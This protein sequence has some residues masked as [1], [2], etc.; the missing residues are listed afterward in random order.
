MELENI[1]KKWLKKLKLNEPLISTILGAV[2]IVIVGVLI[3]NYFKTSKQGEIVTE[4]AEKGSVEFVQNEQGETIPVNLPETYKV[5]ALDNLWKI[6]EKFY[7][8][9]YNWVDIAKANNITNPNQIE[10]GQELKLPQVAVKQ[11]TIAQPITKTTE[12]KDNQSITGTSYKVQKGDSLWKISV[13]AYAD[14]YKWVELA[15]ANNITNPNY[16]E[17]NQELN[18]PR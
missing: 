12:I 17:V 7:Q 8:S 1:L 2:V 18:L 16:I 3:V 6:S 15:K 9:G 14:G 13:R 11:A 10:V 5:E 4:E